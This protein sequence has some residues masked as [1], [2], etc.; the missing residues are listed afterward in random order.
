MHLRGPM[1]VSQLAV[2]QL[3]SEM[4]TMQRRNTVPF[5]NRR[6]AL[7]QR[8]IFRGTD[9]FSERLPSS[10]THNAEILD[11]RTYNTTTSCSRSTVTSTVT[12]TD[13]TTTSTA[14]QLQNTT[15]IGP[16]LPCFPTPEPSSSSTNISPPLSNCTSKSPP[17][18]A[19]GSEQ[20]PQIVATPSPISSAKVSHKRDDVQAADD[21]SRVA[22]YTSTA[23]AQATGFSFLAN[24]GD[25]QKSGTFD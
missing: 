4:H 2:Y 8:D 13:C 17:P 21:W 16:P 10:S 25:P 3:P 15:Y 14:D 18:V 5:Y 9:V 22:Y 23:P 11:K 19:Q 7:K 24:L 12:V 1:N 20:Q 6:R